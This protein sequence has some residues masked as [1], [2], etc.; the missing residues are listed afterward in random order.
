MWQCWVLSSLSG[1][2]CYHW[3][4][5]AV[6][7]RESETMC[8]LRCLAD[9]QCKVVMV[10][11]GARQGYCWTSGG[12]GAHSF[13]FTGF[14]ADL[15]ARPDPMQGFFPVCPPSSGS[16][17]LSLFPS[18]SAAASDS[19]ASAS[20]SVAAATSGNECRIEDEGVLC[21]LAH[22][23]GR[24]RAC[25]NVA[26]VGVCTPS[27]AHYCWVDHGCHAGEVHTGNEGYITGEATI[28]LYQ[29]TDFKQELF[30]AE[31]SSALRLSRPQQLHIQSTAKTGL[32]TL[33]ATFTVLSGGVQSLS[34]LW[35]LFWVYRANPFKLPSF[36]HNTVDG[37]VVFSVEEC[38]S[39][40]CSRQNQ[41]CSN[42]A[43][44]AQATSGKVTCCPAEM[45]PNCTSSLCWADA[46]QC[47]GSS[48][49]SSSS[50]FE[51][52]SQY[53][54]YLQWP[55]NVLHVDTCRIQCACE[56]DPAFCCQTS[57]GAWDGRCSYRAQMG[58][59]ICGPPPAAPPTP[60]TTDT[61]F[62]APGQPPLPPLPQGWAS[63]WDVEES[64]YYY[65]NIRTGEGQ[66]EAPTL[67]AAAV[68][69]VAPEFPGNP[70]AIYF[71]PARIPTP[72]PTAP[73][74][75]P[76]LAVPAV[77]VYIPA[78]HIP[79]IPA[80]LTSS[81]TTLPPTSLP[82]TASP[83]GP[84]PAP[85]SNPTQQ[86]TLL[87]PPEFVAPER[88]ASAPASAPAPAPVSAFSFL[89]VRQP[90]HTSSASSEPSEGSGQDSNSPIVVAPP[91]SIELGPAS[92]SGSTNSNSILTVSMLDAELAPQQ[93]VLTITYP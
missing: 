68:P 24:V 9:S 77:L 51:D 58:C 29:N 79:P 25:C 84:S 35:R 2:G 49:N 1:S 40:A 5:Y 45:T 21:Q 8:R 7:K 76:T 55:P 83:T 82:T 62:L 3:G 43:V 18:S 15:F 14:E 34:S 53:P 16:A 10:G 48:G 74:V 36:P 33:K 32:F 91:G 39:A 59:N 67:N 52:I 88:P 56:E 54:N 50:S 12:A 73:T 47:T 85:T 69:E 72:Q 38:T 93:T 31:L 19:T 89:P 92:A 41:W 4:S 6:V 23:P 28:Q 66:W 26:V 90:T 17:Q 63:A 44:A 80:A 30:Q 71:P 70:P 65:W 27:A 11:Y 46:S 22:N 86:P 81:P 57:P 60:T 61:P 42:G 87:A 20:A 64:K 75:S 13:T 37:H 78:P